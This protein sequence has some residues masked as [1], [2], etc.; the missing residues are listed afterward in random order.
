MYQF[1]FYLSRNQNKC[2]TLNFSKARKYCYRYD[3]MSD[4][5]YIAA[6][7]AVILFIC[8]DM[9][10]FRGAENQYY[11]YWLTYYPVR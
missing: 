4:F 3:N 11:F 10:C 8:K 6:C 2:S 7:F 1:F 5:I 9:H